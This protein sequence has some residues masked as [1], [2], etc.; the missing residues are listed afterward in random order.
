MWPCKI[1]IGVF[2][3]TVLFTEAIKLMGFAQ[4]QKRQSINESFI[5]SRKQ[6]ENQKMFE[7]ARILDR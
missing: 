2:Q 1:A 4:F 3:P 7:I 6:R 5:L